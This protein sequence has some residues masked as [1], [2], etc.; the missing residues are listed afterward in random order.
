MRLAVYTLTRDRLSDTKQ[1][2]EALRNKAGCRFDHFVL[3]NGSTDGTAEWLRQ[4]FI[5]D[6]VMAPDKEWKFNVIS[7]GGKQFSTRCH[8]SPDNLGQC[9]ASNRCLDAIRERGPYDYVLRYDNDI[10]PLTDNFV[11]Q[12]MEAQKLLGRGSIVSPKVDGLLNPPEVF[13]NYTVGDTTFFLVEVIGGACRLAP[14]E[15]IADFRFTE[16]GP[17]ALGE[18]AQFAKY[19]LAAKV[20]MAY[21]KDLH[22]RHDTA[23]HLAAN[24]SYFKRRAI[25]E[26]IPYGL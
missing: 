5:E 16:H 13:G 7:D 8:L 18:A 23:A 11:Q 6:C 3:D 4:I 20:P 24:P 15:R 14:W 21:V 2:F 10:T 12:L 26:H 1:S 17:L 19:C 9:I 22:V 25:E